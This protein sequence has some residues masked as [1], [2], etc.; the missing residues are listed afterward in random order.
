MLTIFGLIFM[1]IATVVCLFPVR[2]VAWYVEDY[3]Q[4]KDV[5]GIPIWGITGDKVSI[6][7]YLIAIYLIIQLITYGIALWVW[8]KA[9]HFHF[10]EGL[11]ELLMALCPVVNIYYVADTW[12]IIITFI[13]SLYYTGLVNIGII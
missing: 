7:S 6:S 13:Y 2:T 1:F 10:W 12:T 8:F 11:K 4:N 5:E 9:D 3:R